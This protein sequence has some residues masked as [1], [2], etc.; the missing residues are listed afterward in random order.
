[1]ARLVA[2]LAATA[3]AAAPAAAQAE[4]ILAPIEPWR[5]SF[6]DGL[7]RMERTFSASGVA[8]VLVLEQVAPGDVLDIALAGPSLAGISQGKPLRLRFGE[9]DPGTEQLPFVAEQGPLGHLVILN[10]VTPGAASPSGRGSINAGPVRPGIDLEAIPGADR[11]A[12]AQ[13]TLQIT[14]ETGALTDAFL[15]LN[16]CT[17]Q[18]MVAW[19]LNPAVQNSL[20]RGS[21]PDRPRRL[22]ETILDGYPQGAVQNNRGGT[23]RAAV[24]INASGAPTDCKIIATSGF[25]DLDRAA[26]TGLMKGRYAAALDAD[27]KAVDSFWTTRITFSPG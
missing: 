14:L 1:M 23:V 19:G 18:I 6:N 21:F 17:A 13:D 5:A 20:Q 15:V 16:E 24:L 9:H 8:H 11:I 7:C 2:A 3:I 25:V 10:D 12:M 22:S 27:G 4:I 26:C